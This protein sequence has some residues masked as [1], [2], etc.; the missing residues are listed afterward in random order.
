MNLI[1]L[2]ICLVLSGLM[3]SVGVFYNGSSYTA[4]KTEAKYIKLMNDMSE[5]SQAAQAA[6]AQKYKFSQYESPTRDL[7]KGGFLSSVPQ[8]DKKFPVDSTLNYRLYKNTDYMADDNNSDWTVVRIVTE[9]KDICVRV[10]EANNLN[11]I[12]SVDGDGGGEDENQPEGAI[13]NHIYASGESLMSFV[14]RPDLIADTVCFLRIGGEMENAYVISHI[15]NVSEARRQLNFEIN[16][17]K[18]PEI[19]N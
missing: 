7:V 14:N 16:Q 17:T 13:V 2:I 8:F 9:N 12:P 19:P 4:S 11:K 6:N 10:N 5:I 18:E 1:S 3:L 15:I